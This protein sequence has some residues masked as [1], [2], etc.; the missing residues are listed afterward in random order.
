VSGFAF[1]LLDQLEAAR[2]K[3]KPKLSL[4]RPM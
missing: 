4:Q 3:L 2:E 1:I